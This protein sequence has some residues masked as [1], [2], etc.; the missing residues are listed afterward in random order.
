MIDSKKEGMVYKYKIEHDIESG[1]MRREAKP[2]PYQA[3]LWH[4][5]AYLVHDSQFGY[6]FGNRDIRISCLSMQEARPQKVVAELH[7]VSD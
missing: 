6:N 1:Q 2:T 4:G 3:S 7:V 5:N